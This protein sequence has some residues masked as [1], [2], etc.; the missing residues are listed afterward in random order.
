MAASVLQSVTTE[1]LTPL[2]MSVYV[3]RTGMRAPSQ[4]DALPYRMLD[5]RFS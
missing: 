2:T 4:Y 5:S 1:N 3:D